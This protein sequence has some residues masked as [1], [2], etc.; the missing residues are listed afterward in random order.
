MTPLLHLTS[1]TRTKRL[2]KIIIK[3]SFYIFKPRS[4]NLLSCFFEKLWYIED[5]EG[6]HFG[7]QPG[8][9]RPFSF[10]YL[11]ALLSS[12]YKIKQARAC[13]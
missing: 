10:F 6:V 7:A 9:I 8:G 2:F 12:I 5:D 11:S 3:Q 1:G 13:S 4:Y